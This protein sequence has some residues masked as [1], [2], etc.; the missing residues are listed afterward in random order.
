MI[1]YPERTWH[2]PD[3]RVRIVLDGS[4]GDSW[5]RVHQGP[6]VVAETAAQGGIVDLGVFA[7]GGYGVTLHTR[8]DTNEVQASTA[9]D[10]LSDAFER[11]RYGFVAGLDEKVDVESLQR[12]SR[13][14]HLNL[15]QFYDW[16][17][18]HSRLMPPADDYVDPLGMPR[19]LTAVN[20]VADAYREAG[21][22]PLGYSAV[23]AVGT[24][25]VA[26]WDDSVIRREDGEP[27][28]LG[29]NFL[30]LVDPG[31]SRWLAHYTEQ[32]AEVIANTQLQG[33]HLDQYGWPK[34]ATTRT[35]RVDLT[36]SFQTMLASVA[37]GVP[38]A[39]IMFNNVNDFPTWATANS[40]QDATYIEVWS[41]HDTL[42]DLNDLVLRSRRLRPEHPPI[43]S[44][45]LS[46]L[47]NDIDGGVRAARLTMASVF[48]AGGTHLLLGEDGHALTD[49]YYP[50]NSVLPAPAVEQF[51]SWY[52]FLVRY[53]DLLLPPGIE[54]VTEYYTGGIN[55]DVVLDGGLSAPK[56][57]PGQV[58][59]RVMRLPDGGHVVHL[60]NLLGLDEIGWDAAKPLQEA[61]TGLALRLANGLV[62]AEAWWAS[63][64]ENASP[65]TALR[66]EQSL[67]A[68]QS[69]SLSAG[70]EHLSFALPAL[71]T[72]G[73]VWIPAASS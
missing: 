53:G 22:V 30:V 36:K 35:E 4:P 41:P 67:A 19:S 44:A 33:F 23:Y 21:T 15:A 68:A 66:S 32:L 17:Y 38:D 31:N 72:W 60:V 9:F 54:D 64:D 43:I 13:R 14:M 7:P 57:M 70:Q 62:P 49:P 25:E 20:R 29:E 69:D 58:W 2:R 50:N 12:F 27:Y 61:V 16:G 1:I 65:M 47:G 8:R 34:F 46:C 42:Q 52:D 40:P 3:E 71:R 11:P 26:D 18:R 73:L 24:D 39:R 56:A 28:R 51:A 55:E 59:I 5:I 63:P 37:A 10:V 48:A 6:W 45:Y